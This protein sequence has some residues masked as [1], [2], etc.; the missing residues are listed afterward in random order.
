MKDDK[1]FV[2]EDIRK[3]ISYNNDKIIKDY[4]K[5]NKN[6]DYLDNLLRNMLIDNFNEYDVNLVDI[7][8][9]NNQNSY[10]IYSRYITNNTPIP[11]SRTIMLECEIELEK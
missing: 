7:T 3:E 6:L 10:T 8:I 4:Y 1:L 9:T 5:E 11:N 2:N